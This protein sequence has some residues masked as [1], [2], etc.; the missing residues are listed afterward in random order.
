MR[1]AAVLPPTGHIGLI[2]EIY[3]DDVVRIW[4]WWEGFGGGGK[5]LQVIESISQRPIGMKW[6]LAEALRGWPDAGIGDAI[7]GAI[8]DGNIHDGNFRRKSLFPLFSQPLVDVNLLPI[9]SPR[10]SGSVALSVRFRS[11][12]GEGLSGRGVGER[13]LSAGKSQRIP[14]RITW[15][16]WRRRGSF[17]WHLVRRMRI[18]R[19]SPSI[20]GAWWSI[21][22]HDGRATEIEAFPHSLPLAPPPP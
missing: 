8:G 9:T 10:V 6:P 20:F 12:R 7:L 21:I 5:R 4:I 15:N 13:V 22:R 16:P 3:R 2:G 1:Q 17:G 11:R 14:W 18:V 19:A